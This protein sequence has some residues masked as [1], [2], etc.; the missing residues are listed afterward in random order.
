MNAG[1]CIIC[2][3]CYIQEQAVLSLALAILFLKMV[4]EGVFT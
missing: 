2:P 3:L 4:S 1:I